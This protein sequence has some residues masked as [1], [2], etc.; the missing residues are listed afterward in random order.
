MRV[1]FEVLRYVKLS[2][3]DGSEPSAARR[4]DILAVVCDVER[5]SA[6]VDGIHHKT[7]CNESTK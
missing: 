7:A 2:G 6:V 4:V 1:I 3:I 5:T